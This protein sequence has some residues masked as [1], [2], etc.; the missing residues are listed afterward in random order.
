M[1]VLFV[2][3]STTS[4]NNMQSF[5]GM[6]MGVFINTVLAANDPI[7]TSNTIR[8]FDFDAQV[9][10]APL[11]HSLP[12]NTAIYHEWP[13]KKLRKT[14]PNYISTALVV[15]PDDDNGSNDNDLPLIGPPIHVQTGDI[16]SVTLQNSLM[17]TGLSIHWHG[18]EMTNALEYDGVVGVTQCPISPNTK[19]V[20][21]FVVEETPGTYVR[22]LLS[23]HV[24][25]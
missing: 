9:K 18:F 19:F 10:Y 20:Y 12:N 3:K 23:L 24:H 14:L 2:Q 13:P 22:Y 5:V 1:Y 7:S 21:E 17:T 16:L 15:T 25:I 6:A 11:L 8:S 4:N